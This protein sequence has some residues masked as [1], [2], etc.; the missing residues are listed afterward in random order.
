[1]STTLRKCFGVLGK[2]LCPRRWLCMRF[3]EIDKAENLSSDTYFSPKEVYPHCQDYL[4]LPV[5]DNN[6]NWRSKRPSSGLPG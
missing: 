4:S 5:G 3:V 2:T 6:D 1:M